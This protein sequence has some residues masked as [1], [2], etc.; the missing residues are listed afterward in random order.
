MV[1]QSVVKVAE[2][3]GFTSFK[4]TRNKQK[5]EWEESQLC[6]LLPPISEHYEEEIENEEE[7]CHML[8]LS[9]FIIIDQV[10]DMSL[11]STLPLSATMI[12]LT[13]LTV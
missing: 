11:E 12:K 3:F 13:S 1:S 4:K 2:R 6:P 10:M 7:Y 9:V 8:R 5:E